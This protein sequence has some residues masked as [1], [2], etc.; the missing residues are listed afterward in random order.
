MKT[1]EE[2]FEDVPRDMQCHVDAD[3][4]AYDF[5]FGLNWSGPIDDARVRKY[6]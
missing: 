5:A 4:N 1:V 3:G 2:Q 6:K